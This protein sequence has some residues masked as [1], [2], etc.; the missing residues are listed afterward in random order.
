MSHICIRRTKEVCISS[1]CTVFLLTV[2]QM[3]DNEGNP[4]I[5]L[6]TVSVFEDRKLFVDLLD[7]GGN[8]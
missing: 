6:P 7:L 1:Q 8:D 3:Q 2:L 4:L 5:E